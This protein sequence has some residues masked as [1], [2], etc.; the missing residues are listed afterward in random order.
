MKN[1]YSVWFYSAEFECISNNNNIKVYKAED[2]RYIGEIQDLEIPNIES[3]DIDIEVFEKQVLQ[4]LEIN[5]GDL[6]I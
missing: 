2:N 3:E 6:K 4:W 1:T 5:F